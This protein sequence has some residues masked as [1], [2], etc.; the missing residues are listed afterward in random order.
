MLY[1]R[2]PEPHSRRWR[3]SARFV[4]QSGTTLCEIR[5]NELIVPAASFEVEQIGRTL[6]VRAD[7]TDLL[8]LELLPPTGLAINQYRLHTSEGEVFIGKRRLTDPWGTTSEKS[9]LEFRHASG[10]VQTFVNCGFRADLGLNL[11]LEG[12]ALVLQNQPTR[13]A[14]SP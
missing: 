5:D 2:E 14:H 9:V 8:E 7:G 13:V 3:L 6:H 12:G 1:L 11:C 10:N 4:D